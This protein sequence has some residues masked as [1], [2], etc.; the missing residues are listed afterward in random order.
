MF[1]TNYI[2]GDDRL[3]HFI[4]KPKRTNDDSSICLMDT[5]LAFKIILRGYFQARKFN[6]AYLILFKWFCVFIIIFQLSWPLVHE[7]TW[8]R[9][10]SV[11]VFVLLYSFFKLFTMI[12]SFHIIFWPYLAQLQKHTKQSTNEWLQ[13]VFLNLFFF[14]SLL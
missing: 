7:Y 2:L 1:S 9:I 12:Y 3:Y 10:N 11:L 6:I 13:Y 4:L 14:Q 8:T 5:L